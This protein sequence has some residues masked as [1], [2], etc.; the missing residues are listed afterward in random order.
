MV[1]GKWQMEECGE[2]I[3]AQSMKQRTKQFALRV[4][5]LCQSLPKTT[6]AQAVRGQLVRSGTSVGCNYRAAQ[7]G[8]SKAE[9]K[10]KLGTVLEE[11]DESAFWLEIIM[12]ANMLPAA[13]VQPLYDE[14]QQLV[15]IFTASLNT[16]RR[17]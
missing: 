15:A 17:N 9:F 8:R 4:L 1:D 13:R 7:R 16:A 10:A 5:K 2:G 14:C 3:N 12:E 11:A 6:E